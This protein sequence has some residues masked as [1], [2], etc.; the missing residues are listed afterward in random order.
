MNLS[1]FLRNAITSV[2]CFRTDYFFARDFASLIGSVRF[3]RRIVIRCKQQ[4]PR[5]A[6]G[7][8]SAASSLLRCRTMCSGDHCFLFLFRSAWAARRR[9][10]S[11]L[12]SFFTNFSGSDL[13]RHLQH[14]LMRCRTERLAP[15]DRFLQRMRDLIF[16]HR[17]HQIPEHVQFVD[18]TNGELRI[19][20]FGED[21]RKGVRIFTAGPYPKS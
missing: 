12:S 5:G 4:T 20:H 19:L 18:G 15:F 3:R 13:F 17:F 6:A 14:V 21:D 8:V 11:V 9:R 1:A 16:R 2:R 7:L 10:R